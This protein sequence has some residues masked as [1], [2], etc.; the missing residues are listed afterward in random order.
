MALLGRFGALRRR[1]LSNLPTIS[2]LQR[3]GNFEL[4]QVKTHLSRDFGSDP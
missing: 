3:A 4:I 2:I 1:H